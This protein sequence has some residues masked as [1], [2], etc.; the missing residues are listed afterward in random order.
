MSKQLTIT[1]PNELSR[2]LEIFK[3]TKTKINIS[4]ICQM[5]LDA[6]IKACEQKAGLSKEAVELEKIIERLRKDKDKATRGDYLYGYQEGTKWARSAS[7]NELIVIGVHWRTS[8]EIIGGEKFDFNKLKE[9]FP[10]EFQENSYHDL[11]DLFFDMEKRY[12]NVKY[13]YKFSRLRF[14][15]GDG[16]TPGEE[17]EDCPPEY[18]QFEDG[19]VQAVRDLWSQI[20]D[21]L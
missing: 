15:G 3:K 4:R 19:F 12:A 5:A 13:D 14:L 9:E 20:K 1:I 2:R 8:N 21:R 11:S 7:Y 16:P 6:E 10:Y 17:S 18:R